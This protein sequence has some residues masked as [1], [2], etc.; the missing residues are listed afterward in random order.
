M[1]CGVQM[2]PVVLKMQELRAE[3]DPENVSA[4]GLAGTFIRSL[5]FSP[6]EDRC[7]ETVYSVKDMK[8]NCIKILISG[9][10]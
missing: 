8:T 2:S 10:N 7:Q 6:N 3:R 1:R 9:Y 5:S 4:L